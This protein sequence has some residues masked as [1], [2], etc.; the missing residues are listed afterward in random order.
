MRGLAFV[1]LLGRAPVELFLVKYRG[2]GIPP[3]A[4]FLNLTTQA[5]ELN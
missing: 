4:E 1:A 2:S 3:P 5:F